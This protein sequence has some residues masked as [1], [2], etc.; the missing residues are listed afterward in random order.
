MGL[1]SAYFK[2]HC[3]AVW[4]VNETLITDLPL[5]IKLLAIITSVLQRCLRH[6]Q[7]FRF[8]VRHS[9]HR[10]NVR[11]FPDVIDTFVF[12]CER[13]DESTE[14]LN[15]KKPL[16]KWWEQNDRIDNVCSHIMVQSNGVQ[17]DKREIVIFRQR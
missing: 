13:F 16:G 11:S 1:F 4:Y 15:A 9:R 3:R 14:S 7:R 10:D 12:H 5:L 8:R 17:R 2:G 6:F